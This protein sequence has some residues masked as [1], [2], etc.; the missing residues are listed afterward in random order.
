MDGAQFIGQS[1]DLESIGYGGTTID[2][3]AAAVLT[4]EGRV[5]VP[6]G[7]PARGA[8]FRSDQFEFAKMGVPAFYTHYGTDIIGRPAGYGAQKRDDYIANFYH[9][10][11]DEIQPWWDFDGAAE[12]TRTL[13]KIGDDIANGDRWPEWKAGSEFK[14]RRDEMMA[15]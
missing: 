12:D 14:A 10:V 7:D 8:F 2:D 11:T 15:R 4:A 9:K 6:D 13:F 3:I 5:L 1:R